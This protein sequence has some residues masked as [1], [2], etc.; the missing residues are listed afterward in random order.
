MDADVNPDIICNILYLQT[1]T[2]SHAFDMEAQHIKTFVNTS[3]LHNINHGYS[4]GIQV[5]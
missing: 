2:I 4:A 1:Y 3:F 5:Y